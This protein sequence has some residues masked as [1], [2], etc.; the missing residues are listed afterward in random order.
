VVG[1]I[2]LVAMTFSRVR[3]SSALFKGGLGSALLVRNGGLTRR[4][5]VEPDAWVPDMIFSLSSTLFFALKVQSDRWFC[6]DSFLGLLLTGM[7]DMRRGMTGA[8]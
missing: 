8:C 5:V 6:K 4:G 3:I 2:G 1:V 7:L